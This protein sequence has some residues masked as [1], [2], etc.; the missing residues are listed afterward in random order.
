M[1]GK[2]SWDSEGTASWAADE[3]T[4]MTFGLWLGLLLIQIPTTSRVL[5]LSGVGLGVGGTAGWGGTHG[6]LGKDGLF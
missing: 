2:E 6:Q 5:R 1:N 4:L 3:E